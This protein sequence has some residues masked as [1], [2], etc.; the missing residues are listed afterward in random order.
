MKGSF[1]PIVD[2]LLEANQ[3]IS[4]TK[5]ESSEYHQTKGKLMACQGILEDNLTKEEIQNLLTKQ[6]ELQQLEQHLA[7]YRKIKDK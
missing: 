5:S 4:K 7:S 1:A 6:I 2:L 3:Q